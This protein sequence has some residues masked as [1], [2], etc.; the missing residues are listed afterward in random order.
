M[1]G[2]KLKRTVQE[3]QWHKEPQDLVPKQRDSLSSS[4][5]R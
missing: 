5:D 3:K 2:L 1:R 4:M